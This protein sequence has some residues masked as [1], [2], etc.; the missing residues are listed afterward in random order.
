MQTPAC[1]SRR[2]TLQRGAVGAL[3]ALAGL[4]TVGPGGAWA[5]AET[6]EPPALPTELRTELPGASP[7]GTAT[8]RFLGVAIYQA[9]LWA[10]NR[11]LAGSYAQS[12]LALELTYFRALSGKRIAERS[13][14]EMQRQ[15]SLSAAQERSW[16]DAMLQAFPDVAAGD[17]I[18]GLH[19]PGVGARFWHNGQSRPGVADAAFSRL[20]FGIWLSEASSEPTMRAQLLGQSAP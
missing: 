1:A 6:A 8:L 11:V 10:G 7:Q 20:F 14:Q 9:R 4:A 15:A 18:T 19:T 16:L 2:R 12:P 17:R 5:A 3:V 13:L